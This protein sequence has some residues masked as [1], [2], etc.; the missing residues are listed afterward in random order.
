MQDLIIR[1]VGKISIPLNQMNAANFT[2]ECILGI[3]CSPPF[4]SLVNHEGVTITTMENSNDEDSFAERGITYS[5]SSTEAFITIP[6][7]VENNDTMISCGAFLS[8]TEFSDPAELIVIGE[9]ELT[10]SSHRW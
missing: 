6:A 5:S 10:R 7:T 2:C 1:P 3:G 8:G 9:S 4:W